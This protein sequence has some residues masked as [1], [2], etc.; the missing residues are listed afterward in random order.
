M[1]KRILVIDDDVSVRDALKKILN[2]SGYSVKLASDGREGADSLARD[3]FDLLVLDL[4]LPNVSGFDILDVAAERDASLP[5]LILTAMADQCETGSV[6][7]ADAVLEKPPD[8]WLL[9]NTIERLLAETPAERLERLAHGPPPSHSLQFPHRRPQL[10]WRTN[11]SP[12]N[13]RVPGNS[14]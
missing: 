9:M 6:A 12:Q 13:R 7:G 4:D 1:K 8:V 11:K 3:K 2:T 10:I 5:I 14:A